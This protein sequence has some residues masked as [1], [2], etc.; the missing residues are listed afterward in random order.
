MQAKC[1]LNI[2]YPVPL[3]QVRSQLRRV[4]S[5]PLTMTLLNRKRDDRSDVDNKETEERKMQ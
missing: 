5:S 1:K 4:I 3:S 2:S